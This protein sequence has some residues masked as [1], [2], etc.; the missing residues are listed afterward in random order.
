[1]GCPKC[2]LALQ[3]SLLKGLVRAWIACWKPIRWS[4]GGTRYRLSSMKILPTLQP[5]PKRPSVLYLLP[6]LRLYI[7]VLCHTFCIAQTLHHAATSDVSSSSTCLTITIR[8][9][10]YEKEWIWQRSCNC[11][12]DFLQRSSRSLVSGTSTSSSGVYLVGS[13]LRVRTDD[14]DTA[15]IRR[16]NERKPLLPLVNPERSSASRRTS[17]L[18][19][20]NIDQDWIGPHAAGWVV[21]QPR[22]HRI[23]GG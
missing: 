17:C 15:C 19:E 5:T 1:V 13:S 10:S 21:G 4:S 2:D 6:P 22:V 11:S 16:R 9:R 3:D 18:M 20:L 14:R 7:V 12:S 23:V 8:Q